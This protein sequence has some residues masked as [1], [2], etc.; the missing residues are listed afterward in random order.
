[1]IKPGITILLLLSAP[2]EAAAAGRLL[3]YENRV[4]RAAEQIERIKTDSAYSRERNKLTL[5]AKRFQLTTPGFMFCSILTTPSATLS[6]A[7]LNST[8]S[9]GGSERSM[10]IFAAPWP[11]RVN[12]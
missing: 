12:N 1:M 11:Q 2:I 3:T 4:V 10:S 8:K 5:R 7:W 6:S 9:P